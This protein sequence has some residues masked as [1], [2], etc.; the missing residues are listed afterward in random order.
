[1]ELSFAREV[2]LTRPP[3]SKPLFP[4][5][6]YLHQLRLI[7]D[8]VGTPKEADLHFVQS[9][10]ALKYMR[11]LGKSAKVCFLTFGFPGKHPIQTCPTT[12]N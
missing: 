2:E 9:E 8:V 11:G 12:I 10:K 4:G 3:R 1:V 5:E 6:D 7:A